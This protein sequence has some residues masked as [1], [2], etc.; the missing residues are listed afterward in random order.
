MISELICWDCCIMNSIMLSNKI[1]SKPD[2]LKRWELI[3][4]MHKIID[5]VH[6]NEEITRKFNEIEVK[7]LS[8]LDFKSLFEVLLSEIKRQFKIPYAWISLVDTSEAAHL[9]R[10]I[11]SSEILRDCL[12]I[13][14]KRAFSNLVGVSRKSV[15]VNDRL[16]PYLILFPQNKKCFI[17]SM[18][19]APISLDGEIIGSLN[20]ADFS[21]ERF[22]PGI[23]T[24]LLEQLAVKVSL[25][26]SN[27]TAH[28]KLSYL[29]FHDPLTGLLNRRVMEIQL[30][31]EFSRARR[32]GTPLSISFLDL[33]DFKL[34]NDKYGHDHGD[35]VLKYVGK[36]LVQMCRESDIVS[37]FA[38]DEF[39]VVLPETGKESARKLMERLQADLFRSPMTIGNNS[40]KVS[41][42]F[43]VAS[44]S[45]ENFQSAAMFLKRAD[46]N[47]YESKAI[48]KKGRIC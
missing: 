40:V 32:Y 48:R 38:G 18:A 9:I 47:L 27:V 24:S 34:I 26:L 1:D 35:E 3:Q 16:K 4:E 6:K 21:A 45:E 14:E 13:V 37:R 17:K 28:E 22:Q 12:K 19:I 42:S 36:A 11:K 39:V 30:E 44:I 20:Q 10:S 43:G 2:S 33:D 5:L 31:K 15:L 7:I 41:M 25:C 46:E 23:D 29:A 8:I